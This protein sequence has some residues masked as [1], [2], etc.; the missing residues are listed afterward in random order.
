MVSWKD[1]VYWLVRQ[2]ICIVAFFGVLRLQECMD[3][4]LEKVQRGKEGYIITRNRAKQRRS[5]K[6]ESRFV[7]PETGGYA[8]Q[9]ALYLFK[10]NNQLKKYQGTVWC[11]GT[12]SD[13]LKNQPMGRN[14]IAKLPHDIAT[15]LSLANPSLYTIRSIASE[16]LLPP[17]L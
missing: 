8:A 17:A 3:L 14:T 13:M 9:L 7:V 5:D 16:G 1:N 15:L 10:V 2:P 6:L 12:Q 4:V 11:T